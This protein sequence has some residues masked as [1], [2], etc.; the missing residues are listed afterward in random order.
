MSEHTFWETVEAKGSE[1]LE[2]VK[3][4][5]AEGNVR[6][7]RVR[8]KH[9]VIAEFPLTIGVVGA[10]LAPVLAALGAIAALVTECSIEVERTV[11]PPAQDIAEPASDVTALIAGA[12]GI[13]HDRSSS[14]RRQAPGALLFPADVRDLV[15]RRAPGDRRRRQH[16]GH[17]AGERSEVP[18]RHARDAGR[19]SVSAVS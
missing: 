2:K 1:I 9:R 14:D 4:L 18:V 15:G 19:S 8:T 5:I 11:Q 16:G 12:G 3:E 6:S 13:H 7:V 10:V 17:D